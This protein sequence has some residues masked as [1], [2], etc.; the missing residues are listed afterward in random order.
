M[1]TIQQRK[2]PAHVN[3]LRYAPTQTGAKGKRAHA[4]VGPRAYLKPARSPALSNLPTL[5]QPKLRIGQPNDKYEA[6]ADRV[7]NAVMR[8]PYSEMRVQPVC[9]ECEGG[10]QRQPL[11]KPVEEDLRTKGLAREEGHLFVADGVLNAQIRSLRGRGQTLPASARAFFEPRL[12]ND[13]GEVRIH[14]DSR[15]AELARS[16]DARAFTVGWD[17]IFGAGQYAPESREGRRLLAHELTHVVQQAAP[18]MPLKRREAI[19]RGRISGPGGSEDVAIT[20]K[21]LPTLSELRLQRQC[22]NRR[23]ASRYP[24]LARCDVTRRSYSIYDPAASV[25]PMFL[26]PVTHLKRRLMKKKRYA[27][28]EFLNVDNKKIDLELAPSGMVSARDRIFSLHPRRGRS[29]A[30]GTG[31]PRY[32]LLSINSSRF[33]RLVCICP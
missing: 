9:A 8:M 16:V 32:L 15:S 1:S 31:I 22:N 10:L 13:F 25:P 20:S 28:V 11:E 23:C 12:A 14:T 5:L 24:W 17:V 29:V 4:D 27:F 3:P 6:E 19:Y 18:A 21:Q 30:I 7:A 26:V 33:V 2:T